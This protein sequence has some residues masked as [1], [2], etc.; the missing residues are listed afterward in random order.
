MV[1][2]GMPR[3]CVQSTFSALHGSSG[4]SAAAAAGY[5]VVVC[6]AGLQCLRELH[7]DRTLITDDGAAFVKGTAFVFVDY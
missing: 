6:T 2:L 4:S 7:L 1:I 5:L 3:L